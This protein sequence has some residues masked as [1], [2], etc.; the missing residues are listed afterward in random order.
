MPSSIAP[1]PGAGQAP[2]QGVAAVACPSSAADPAPIVPFGPYAW[3]AS[4]ALLLP[5]SASPGRISFLTTF[6]G[7]GTPSRH[8]FMAHVLHGRYVLGLT[9]NA[10]GR[11]IQSLLGILQ[12]FC[13]DDSDNYQGS[14]R[15]EET[16][17]RRQ[18][19]ETHK[20]GISRGRQ[21]NP[22]LSRPVE[23]GSKKGSAGMKGPRLV[24][25][26]FANEH[27]AAL[28]TDGEAAET[29]G[30]GFGRPR[31]GVP[32]GECRDTG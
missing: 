25:N 28:I 21:I 23:F 27:V 6:R 15:S 4:A 17:K 3:P 32:A 18:N 10:H 29:F 26:R 5:V 16:Q 22:E 1:V 14:H 31:Q 7:A 24:T 2:A 9:Q 30:A 11:H 8:I 13:H 19:Y 12:P 20:Q